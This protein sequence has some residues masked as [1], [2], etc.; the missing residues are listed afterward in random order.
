M[1]HS[2][3]DESRGMRR[4]DKVINIA[5]YIFRNSQLF[6]IVLSFPCFARIVYTIPKA[7]HVFS[8]QINDSTKNI[9][10]THDLSQYSTANRVCVGYPTGMKW[11]QTTWNLHGQRKNFALGTQR[12]LYSTCSPWGF[13]LG[14]THI[15]SVRIGGNANFRVFSPTCWYPQRKTLVLGVLPNGMAQRECFRASVEYRL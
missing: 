5:I 6:R 1:S 11:A 15:F 10:G 14:V 4:N 12:D 2:T 7:G 13:A 3:Q 9:Y 8:N